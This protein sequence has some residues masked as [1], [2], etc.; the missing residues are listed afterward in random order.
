MLLLNIKSKQK[1]IKSEPVKKDESAYYV[2]K[3]KRLFNQDE[4]NK[5]WV[6]D[7]TELKISRN[8]F[9]LCVNKA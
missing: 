7:V 6:S 9:Y 4:P 8:K 1:L 5:Y 2:N 3:L